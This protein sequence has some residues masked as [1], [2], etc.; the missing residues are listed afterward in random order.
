MRRFI[1]VLLFGI[2][3]T[4]LS[5]LSAAQTYFVSDLGTLGGSFSIPAAI[6]N[7]L[8]ITRNSGIAGLWGYYWAVV[9]SRGYCCTHLTGTNGER[10]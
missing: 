6:N 10:S 3:F 8:E 9:T 4:P 1:F 2:C 7:G 5:S